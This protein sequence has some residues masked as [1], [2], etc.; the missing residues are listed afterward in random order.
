MKYKMIAFDMDGTLLNSYKKISDNTINAIEKVMEKGIH[1]IFNTGR[2]PS[3]L[4]EYFEVLD[5][6]Y[7]NCISGALVYDRKNDE[8]I[9]SLS[10]AHED[11]LKLLEIAKKEDVMVQVLN[12]ES[13][14][15]QEKFNHIEKYHMGVYRDMYD[16]VAIKVEDLYD[17]Y[18]NNPFSIEKLNIY[19]TC[20]D[21]RNKTRQRIQDASLDIVLAN[22]EETSLECSPKGVSKAFGLYKLCEHLNILIDD[23]IVVGDADN[24]IE[25]L[26]IAG[27]SVAMGNAKQH[28]KDMC[29]IVVSDN[30]HDG[31]VEVIEKF[32]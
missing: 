20:E 28:I 7:L 17:E 6:R 3:E 21:A 25:A 19:H 27:L 4:A 15:E 1:V 13:I 22:A 12:T 26:K 24:D 31:C 10:L 16:R 5:I 23:V 32:F 9:S 14:I 11:V 18:K 2:C 8:T 29:D 30:D